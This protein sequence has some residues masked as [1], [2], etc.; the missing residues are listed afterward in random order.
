MK[1]K[2]YIIQY[3]VGL[4]DGDG[5]IQVNHWRMKSLQYRLVIKLKLCDENVHLLREIK[6]YVGGNVR[7]ESKN[8]FVLWVE[9]YKDKIQQ[10]VKHLVVYPPLTTRLALQLEFL[11]LCLQK[12]DVCWYL[13]NRGNKY[14]N[15][16]RKGLENAFKCSQINRLPY[17]RAWLSGFIEAGG[18][19]SHP[20]KDDSSAC[21]S[22]SI[23]QKADQY[24]LKSIKHTFHAS[25]TIKRVTNK[26]GVLRKVGKLPVSLPSP[27]KQTFSKVRSTPTG[28]GYASEFGLLEHSSQ[29]KILECNSSQVLSERLRSHTSTHPSSSKE[30]QQVLSSSALLTNKNTL[31]IL[32]IYRKDVLKRI[33]SHLTLYPLLGEK[34]KS[35]LLFKQEFI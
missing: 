27:D 5:S 17:Y 31:F 14:Q 10:I 21:H 18:C 19:F 8:R 25:N 2:D 29:S 34:N 9:N 26:T 30:L 15:T 12:N 33:I 13:Q 11:L 23:S 32:E 35:F 20:C 1:R 4:M 6:K 24:L 22:F 28:F 3:W 16:C 7:I